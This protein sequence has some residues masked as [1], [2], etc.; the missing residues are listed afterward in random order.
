MRKTDFLENS[1]VNGFI[2]WLEPLMDKPNSFYHSYTTSKKKKYCEFTNLYDALKEY[3]YKLDIKFENYAY[4]LRQAVDNDNNETCVKVCYEIIE[5]GGVKRNLKHIDCRA[6]YLSLYLRDVRDRLYKDLPLKEYNQES[7]YM[8]SGFSKIYSAFIDD[9]II[10]DSR[11]SASLGLF[12]RLFLEE[13][14]ITY[15]PKQLEFRLAPGRTNNLRNP[16][17]GRYIFKGI[18]MRNYLEYNIKANW[19][20]AGIADRTKSKFATIERNLRPREIE[21][22]LFQVGYDLTDFRYK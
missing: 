1:Y 8:S 14:N 20:L 5:W 17:K 15:I 18:T 9:F 21:R 4:N 13:S 19:L 10:Y 2:E 11:V 16:E 12:I 6:S 22:A 7:I 3:D